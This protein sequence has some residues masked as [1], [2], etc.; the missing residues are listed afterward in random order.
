MIFF[1]INYSSVSHNLIFYTKTKHIELIILN[2]VY[3]LV[4]TNIPHCW[5]NNKNEVFL[6]M[7]KFKFEKKSLVVNDKFIYK[8]SDQ[9][10]LLFTINFRILLNNGN[11]LIK[12]K[13]LTFFILQL[14][15]SFNAS[16]FIFKHTLIN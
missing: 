13:G 16:F 5:A 4:I 6:I 11:I 14:R 12:A 1:H 15:V 10:L 2:I 9:N 3:S 8:R 7:V